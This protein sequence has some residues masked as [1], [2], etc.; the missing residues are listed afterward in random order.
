M[1]FA[2]PVVSEADLVRYYS[3]ELE[4]RLLFLKEDSATGP[5]PGNPWELDRLGTVA[6]TIAD[7]FPKRNARV[8]DVGCGSGA[9]LALLRE[10]G[11]HDL[12]GIEPSP[13]SVHLG[14]E[15]GLEVRAGS[16]AA[17]PADLGNFDCIVLSHVLE[18]LESPSEALQ[19]VAPLL[20][21]GGMLYVEV[22]DATRFAELAKLPFAEFNTEHINYFSPHSLQS[23]LRKNGFA[24]ERIETKSFSLLPRIP[25]PAV[26]G[27][28]RRDGAGGLDETVRD[29]CLRARIDD[30]VQVSQVLTR[31]IDEGLA[32][33]LGD[34]KEVVVRCLGNLA[35]TLLE[36]TCLRDLDVR[37]YLDGSSIKQRLTIDGCPIL[38]PNTAVPE[39]L[40]VVI[41]SV[42]HENAV[43]KEIRARE[44]GRVAFGVSA[45]VL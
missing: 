2:D 8:L 21:P 4:F 5:E 1:A 37:A 9:L 13:G 14:Q 7:C 12:L 29:E 15:L 31:R 28:W 33:L 25:Y 16:L 40:P 19:T 18:H 26:F 43:M 39:K 35:W 36:V 17:L 10:L 30:Y 24:C 27:L 6:Q 34:Q 45:F 23:L 3:S 44:P 32:A 11:F 20:G 41:L 38:P 22:P 42:Q